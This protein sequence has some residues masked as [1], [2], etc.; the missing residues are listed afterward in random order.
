MT[1]R[2]ALYRRSSTVNGADAREYR[3]APLLVWEL[4][5]AN[6]VSPRDA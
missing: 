3:S 2:E 6:G 4:L 1:P 5:D